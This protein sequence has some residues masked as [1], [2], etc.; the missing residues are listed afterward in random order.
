MRKI[1]PFTFNILLF[2][3][4][5]FVLPFL[6]LYY[7]SLGFSG[8][9][10]GLLTGITPLVTIVCAPL[11]TAIADKT[12]HHR[13]IMSLALLVGALVVAAFPL[14]TAFAPILLIALVL[15]IF[16]SPVTPLADSATMYMLADQKEMYGRI[17]LGGTI[18]FGVASALAGMLVESFGINLAFWG[19]AALFLLVFVVSQ[20]LVYNPQTA[21]GSTS[22]G[23]RVLLANR[24]WLLFL[25]LAFAG[26]FALTATNLYL[27]PYMNELGAPESIM[28]LA[29]TIGT[30]AEIPVLFFGNRLLRR[31]KPYGLL[32]LS[33]AITGARLVALAAS[34][35]PTHILMLQLLG[36]LTFPAMWI[37]S[38]A[39]ADQNAPAGLSATAQGLLGAMVFGFGAA[40]GGFAAGLLLESVGGRGLYFVFGTTV[41]V[42]TGLVALLQRKNPA[43]STEQ[44]AVQVD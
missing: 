24:R 44:P 5:A 17:R 40:V 16:F 42:I 11:W 37:A 39:Y 4:F 7:Q 18:G 27:F 26:G 14:F 25:T 43:E 33:M 6:V 21:S 32:M 3:G 36:G 2:A 23:I 10:I 34:S 38:V 15:N 8:A 30:I 35:T 31:F 22:R 41:L 12:Q 9:Q 1:W 28:G 29:L 13:L 19:S 20:K